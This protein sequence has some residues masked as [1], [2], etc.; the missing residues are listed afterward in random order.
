MSGERER[1]REA[2]E[3]LEEVAAALAAGG[4]DADDMARLAEEAVRVSETITRLLPAALEEGEGHD[5][6]P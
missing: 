4:E 1:L 2:V 5:G 6:R 3:R